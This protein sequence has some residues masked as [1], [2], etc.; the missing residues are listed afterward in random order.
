MKLTTPFGVGATAE[1]ASRM[2]SDLS[3]LVGVDQQHPTPQNRKSRRLRSSSTASVDGGQ[4]RVALRIV[5][6]KSRGLRC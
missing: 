2:T 6:L 1:A 4:R 3:Q 5:M